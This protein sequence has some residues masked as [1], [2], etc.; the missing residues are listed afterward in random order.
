MQIDR[1]KVFNELKPLLK[2][3]QPLL[4]VKSD[5]EG[6]YE[7]YSTRPLM[8]EGKHK[9]EVFF[10][11]LIVQSNYVSF[12][13]MPIYTHPQAFESVSDEMKRMLKGKSC[14]H[15]KKFDSKTKDD[16]KHILEQGY[17]IYNDIGLT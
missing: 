8:Y 2:E 4:N 14:F 5:F 11:S 15:I 1:I 7:L 9:E 17:A 10:S 12:H 16:I 3:Y 6:R 13:F